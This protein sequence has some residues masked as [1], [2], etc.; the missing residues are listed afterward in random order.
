MGIRC[1][2]IVWLAIIGA[3][4]LPCAAAAAGKDYDFRLHAYPNPFV[5]GYEDASLCYTVPADGVASLEVYDLRGK[6]LRTITAGAL[7]PAGV[8]DG[9]DIWDGRDRD[10]EIVLPG[11][12]VIILEIAINGVSYRDSF[13]A[14]VNR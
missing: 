3:C 6:L 4:A 8:Y 9:D 14:V 1:S 13:I 5:P 12:Y 2:K 10:G 11:A 7:R